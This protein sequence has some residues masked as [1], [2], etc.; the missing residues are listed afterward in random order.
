VWLEETV[1]PHLLACTLSE[2]P[3][4][5]PVEIDGFAANTVIILLVDL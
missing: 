1:L 5:P 3:G 2:H 4:V